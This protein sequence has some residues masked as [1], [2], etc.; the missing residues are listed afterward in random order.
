MYK[1]WLEKINKR[2]PGQI[3][4]K[5]PGYL[6]IIIWKYKT[7]KKSKAEALL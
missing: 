6:F 7:R 4:N 2:Y 5:C 3:A 1:K